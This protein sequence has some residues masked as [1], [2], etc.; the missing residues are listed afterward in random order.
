MEGASEQKNENISKRKNNREIK[1]TSGKQNTSREKKIAAGEIQ[2]VDK[3]NYRDRKKIT[4]V[5][6]E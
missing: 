6:K 1:L 2:Q 5:E 3:E 4:E